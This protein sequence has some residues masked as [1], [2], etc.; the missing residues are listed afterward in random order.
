MVINFKDIAYVIHYRPPRN[1][2]EFLP[3]IGRAGRDGRK[4]NLPVFK[5]ENAC[6]ILHMV[7]DSFEDLKLMMRH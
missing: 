3:E 6:D 7:R 5:K 1:I 4:A 2:E